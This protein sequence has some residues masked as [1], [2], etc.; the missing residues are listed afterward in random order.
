MMFFVE[1]GQQ[2]PLN[3]TWLNR[4]AS[5]YNCHWRKRT[6]IVR[7]SGKPPL[8]MSGRDHTTRHCLLHLSK[9]RPS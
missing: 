2:K 6:E 9:F 1:Q 5:E 8:L 7:S 3:R 4:R